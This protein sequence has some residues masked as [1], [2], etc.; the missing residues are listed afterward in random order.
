MSIPG[1]QPATLSAVLFV[2]RA[3]LGFD[4]DVRRLFWLLRRAELRA[5][6]RLALQ[7]IRLCAVRI[8]QH[9][10]PGDRETIRVLF[11]LYSGRAVKVRA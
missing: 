8:R 11:N 2:L 1:A 5:D 6:H 7:T 9:F 3:L 10:R 4:P